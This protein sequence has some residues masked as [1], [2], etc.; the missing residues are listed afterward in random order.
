MPLVPKPPRWATTALLIYALQR[1]RTPF[2]LLCQL[3]LVFVARSALHVPV[4]TAAIIAGFILAAYLTALIT[5]PNGKQ[6]KD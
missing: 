6:P 4:Q 1:P 2:E 3:S 5:F